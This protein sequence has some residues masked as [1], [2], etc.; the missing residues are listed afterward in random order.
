MPRRTDPS[1]FATAYAFDEEARVY[2]P[3]AGPDDLGYSD[4]DATEEGLLALMRQASDRSLHS[5]E[6]A[7]RAVDWP[8]R[9]HLS[10][11]RAN[12]L[13]PF[14]RLLRG[15]TLEV[16]SGCGV[17][18]RYLGELGGHVVAIEGSRRR[19]AITAARC[20][21][22]DNVTVVHERLERF[23]PDQRFSAITLVGVLEWASR[24][25][26]GEDGARRVIEQAARL[27]ADDGVLI[28]AIENQLGL[29]YF[30][31][32]PEDHLDVAMSGVNDAHRPGEPRTFGLRELTSLV[33][34]GG[35][36]HHA[37]YAPFPD[38][39]FP[40]VV[41][42]PSG[43][44]D[45]A[46]SADL[47]AM[48][49][50]TPVTD[51]QAPLLPLF[52]LEQA[53]GLAARNGLLRDLS[54]SF[55][56]VA[57]R[58]PLTDDADS[59]ILAWHFSGERRPQYLREARFRRTDRG[60]T[61]EHRSLAPASA[62]SGADAPIR[63]RESGGTFVTGEV[64]TTRL[65]R[66]LNRPGW[67]IAD[68]AV[69]AAP[70]RDA[71]AGAAG[72]HKPA[73]AAHLPSH[74]VDATPFNLVHADGQFRFF[75]L[76]WDL[77]WRVEY[78]YA[79]F[80]GLF[81]SLSRFRSV[82]E[83]AEGV[84]MRVA[85]LCALLADALGTP[86]TPS[87]ISRYLD[88][89]A[90]LQH[91]VTGVPSV[92]AREHLR[93]QRLSPR[94]GL[95]SLAGLANQV[96]SLKEV[97]R[98]LAIGRDDLRREVDH[99]RAALQEAGELNAAEREDLQ[100]QLVE[101]ERA[102]AQM[103]SMQASLRAHLDA[104]EDAH[105]ATA[106]ALKATTAERDEATHRLRQAEADEAALTARADA[107]E[108]LA[109]E[110]SLQLRAGQRAMRQ[111]R[112]DAEE[113]A[114]RALAGAAEA[115][116]GPAGDGTA[117]GR[118]GSVVSR[119]LDRMRDAH[120]RPRD[121]VRHPGTLA[122]GL[123]RLARA[124]Y[125]AQVA[126]IAESRL[127]DAAHYR[128]VTGLPPG[129]DI[130]GH[131]LQ[132]GDLANQSPHPL[133][134]PVWYRQ[135]NPD[136]PA[137][138]GALMHYLRNGG[139]ELRDPHP[140]FDARH[141][142]S[143]WPADAVHATTPLSHFARVGFLGAA[144]PHPLFD[145]AYYVAQRPDLVRARANPLVHYLA[146]AATEMVDPHPVFSTRFYLE[147]N[148]D[149]GGANPLDHF[150]RHGAAEARSPHPLFDIGYYWQQRP[151]VR[152]S[153]ENALAALPAPCA[154]RGRGSASAVRHQLLPRR[155]RRTCASSARTRWRTSWQRAGATASSRIRGSIRR[156]TSIG[157][158]ICRATV[159]PLLHYLQH[160]W[161]EDRD[162][163]PAFSIRDTSGRI[164]TYAPSARS[165]VTHFLGLG[166]AEGRTAVGAATV[167]PT[168]A[169][170]PS[171]VLQVA[172]RSTA[173]PT[174]LCVSHVSPWPV[175]AGNEYRLSRLLTHLQSRGHRIVLVLA[176]I[177]SEPL[178]PGAF[179]RLADELG[180]VVLCRRDGR[181]E[182]RL[183]DVPD[184]L[185]SLADVPA[186]SAPGPDPH[187]DATERAFCHDTVYA[188]TLA[189]ARALGPTVVVAEY[190]FMTRIFP[191]I[192]PESLRVV[193]TH[194]VFSQKGTN[195]IAYGIDDEEVPA[196]DEGRLASRADVVV[197]IHP[198]D[199]AAL[200]E[201]APG[202]DVIVT[203]V[204]ASVATDRPW[205][206]RPVA[207]LPG[208]S[209]PLNVAGLRDFLRFSWPRVL[210]AVPEA[211]L[212]VAGGV[213]RAVRPGTPGVAVLGH[214]PDL[215]DE[216]RSSRVVINPAVAGT[217]LKIKTIEALAHLTPVVGWPH[218][219][220]GLSSDLA[221][222]VHEATDWYDFADEVVRQLERS[223]SPFGAEAIAAITR[224][225][226]PAVVYRDLDERLDRFLARKRAD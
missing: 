221:A 163:S 37:V 10:P 153:G 71:L 194:D 119:T 169:P 108:Q 66:I 21:G 207:F 99:H 77:P 155:R 86:C 224:E 42:S 24:F 139:W 132:I 124:P 7:A 112:L 13:R 40:R 79:L 146:T 14:E 138:D 106:A 140:L 172:G 189:L 117:N 147:A 195:V 212:R 199:A 6:L 90:D 109:R 63:Q 88:I 145:A 18:T 198:A 5:P 129:A 154:A 15:R 217:G 148:P 204:D 159:N 184:V 134:D 62:P 68:V 96:E 160:G 58:R 219:R 36:A 137:S 41:V 110:Q 69:W 202:R 157:T 49:A 150:V 225:L 74:L 94:A 31:G 107:A 2:V 50:A 45:R 60:I 185:A 20:R 177:E 152:Q 27:L 174:V 56:V 59:G 226:S 33:T 39:K 141:Y 135:R 136:V 133:F 183:R 48:A 8:T 92:S 102:Q 131:F 57:G 54:N 38:Y 126:L 130:L 121:A 72:L 70:W 173:P 17:L 125:R 19:A 82:A 213:G 93:R 144:S 180:N 32:W 179:E 51:P 181:V 161:R 11:V 53:M 196:A 123:A 188:T 80:R 210:A 178:A 73:A 200:R 4:G 190:I 218:N 127:F 55:V 214:V 158:G 120:V 83:P 143:Q 65:G 9:Y 149:T 84:P 101:A 64:W 223:S 156:G 85:D 215:A 25:V 175:R 113:R 105:R 118:R 44:D 203:G 47:V 211:E 116:A 34:G 75:D 81:W 165:R 191:A 1:S 128:A 115:V 16:G 209:N 201:L 122:R 220:D 205:P 167:E 111:V 100:R 142:L 166:R 12:L 182:Y 26:E 187:L 164:R 103:E 23:A 78:G 22:L 35:L 91:E 98:Q 193:D 67:T 222:F 171:V 95:E 208:S 28:I 206:T 151:D 162:P 114:R 46:W 87:D 216:Y 30:A 168:A 197:A 3:A 176:P 89:E 170:R 192:G 76:E 186:N 61:L 29:K 52:S 43:L 97:N 104:S